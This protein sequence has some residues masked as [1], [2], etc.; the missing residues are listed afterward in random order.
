VRYLLRAS[1]PNLHQ[2]PNPKKT[3]LDINY[4][5]IFVAGKGNVFVKGD[6]A[7]QEL[8]VLGEV[9]KDENLIAA[10]NDNI[11]V[12]LLTANSIFK[13]GLSRWELCTKHPE[14]DSNKK[15]YSQERHKAKNGVNF[16]VVYGTSPMGISKRMGVSRKE[17]KSWMDEFFGLFP[18]VKD[19]IESTREFLEQHGYIAIG[20][21]LII[22]FKDF[23]LK[24]RRLRQLNVWQ[25]CMNMELRWFL[26]STMNWFLKYQNQRQ[27]SL[28]RN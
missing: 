10:F 26:K 6:W 1:E 9:S 12:H 4:R 22:G 24:Q 18:G 8:R 25:F 16:P 3:K 13:L 19:A 28:L 11:D 23:L 20:Q 2:L 15:K 17:A 21:H 7:G 14:Y 5:E 27:K